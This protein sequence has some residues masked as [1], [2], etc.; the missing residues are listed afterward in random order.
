MVSFVHKC[1]LFALC[2]VLPGR[3]SFHASAA[4]HAGSVGRVTQVIGAVVDVQFDKD[5]PPIFNALEVCSYFEVLRVDHSATGTLTLLQ[6]APSVVS[7]SIYSCA[8]RAP[9]TES[10]SSTAVGPN[11]AS[12]GSICQQYRTPSTSGTRSTNILL[13]NAFSNFRRVSLQSIESGIT[14]NTSSIYSANNASNTY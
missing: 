4:V 12:T 7:R 11:T 14:A 1:S 9:S 8:F 3:A 6:N 2:D 10:P 5:L 13:I